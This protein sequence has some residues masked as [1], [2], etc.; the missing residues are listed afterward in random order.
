[1]RFA[2]VTKYYVYWWIRQKIPFRSIHR[3]NDIV[4]R[5]SCNRISPT[6][7]SNRIVKVITAWFDITIIIIQSVLVYFTRPGIFTRVHYQ[8]KHRGNFT[9]MKI[10]LP[11]YVYR[12]LFKTLRYSLWLF[13]R[14]KFHIVLVAT[15]R[16][17]FR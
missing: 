9:A 4:Y 13:T 10:S 1:M 11:R 3:S 15:R 8:W 6:S 12:S 17:E 14:H 5:A 2:N 16:I 7:I